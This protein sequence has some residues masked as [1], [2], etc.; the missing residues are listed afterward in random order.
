MHCDGGSNMHWA[1]GDV[2]TLADSLSQRDAACILLQMEVPHEV[3]EAVAAA[4]E[5]AGSPV[6]QDVGGAGN[7]YYFIQKS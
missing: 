1:P 7:Y 4:A 6:F 5:R 2:S 3:N